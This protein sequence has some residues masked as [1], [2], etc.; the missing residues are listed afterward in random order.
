MFERTMELARQRAEQAARK[1]RDEIARR[2]S[3]E[4]PPGIASEAMED[5]VRLSAPG[6]ARRMALE[7]GLRWLVAGLK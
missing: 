1:R 3:E 7:P 4:L 5:G 2:V 6:L